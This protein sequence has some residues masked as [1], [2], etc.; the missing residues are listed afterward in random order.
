[1][2]SFQAR[3]AVRLCSNHTLSLDLLSRTLVRTN[4]YKLPHQHFV[5]CLN[6]I[7][8]MQNGPPSKAYD[9]MDTKVFSLFKVQNTTN[10]LLWYNLFHKKL[11]RD[12]AVIRSSQ[13]RINR[14]ISNVW[15]IC[16]HKDKSIANNMSGTI[17]QLLTP[18]LV[19]ESGWFF[20]FRLF[21]LILFF[22]N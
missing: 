8:R 14:Y 5:E 21:Q 11:T 1:M 22:V 16:H 9:C 13:R 19:G 17:R 20:I 3:H 10:I 18:R 12:K 7:R 6:R 15:I 4:L 2:C